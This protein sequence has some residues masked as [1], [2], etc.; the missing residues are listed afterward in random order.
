MSV[1]TKIGSAHRQKDLLFLLSTCTAGSHY[2]KT[3]ILQNKGNP[4][5]SRM[6]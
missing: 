5:S 2:A 6:I 1:S 3:G 4:I